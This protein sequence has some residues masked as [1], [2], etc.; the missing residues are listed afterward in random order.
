MQNHEAEQKRPFSGII[1]SIRSAVSLLSHA[2]ESTNGHS[3]SNSSNDPSADDAHGAKDEEERKVHG[4]VND[5]TT[6]T[7]LLLDDSVFRIPATPEITRCFPPQRFQLRMGC[8]MIDWSG[9]L[10]TLRLKSEQRWS[11]ERRTRSQASGVDVHSLPTLSREEIRRHNTP[12]DLWLV[13]N[14]VVYNCTRFQYF[15]PAGERMLQLCGGRDCTD[16]FNHFHRWVSCEAMLGPFAVG[17][18]DPAEA[19]VTGARDVAEWQPSR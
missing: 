10:K 9:I 11:R 18:V 14:N 3:D 1:A 16:L 2:E 4:P 13:V 15:H 5:G 17:V 7:Q 12:D 8:S 19:E 6:T